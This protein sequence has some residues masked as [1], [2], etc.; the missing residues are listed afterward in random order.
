MQTNDYNIQALSAASTLLRSEIATGRL[1]CIVNRS[2]SH[3][4]P[5]D[6]VCLLHR[7]SSDK[8][9]SSA[10]VIELNQRGNCG[11]L[12][13][14]ATQ[15]STGRLCHRCGTKDRSGLAV[16]AA[17]ALYATTR[18]PSTMSRPNNYCYNDIWEEKRTMWEK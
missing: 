16:C 4:C 6:V 5:V 11:I 13:D 3:C 8:E 7:A 12:I 15:Y 14:D 2:I 17:P 1:H 9:S 18:A 10:L